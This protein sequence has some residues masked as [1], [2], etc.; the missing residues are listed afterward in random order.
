VITRVIDTY[1]LSPMQ[2]RKLFHA[3]C[4][5]TNMACHD[6]IPRMQ[7]DLKIPLKFKSDYDES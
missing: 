4:E 2:A 5:G 3:S 7:G 1:E 6:A